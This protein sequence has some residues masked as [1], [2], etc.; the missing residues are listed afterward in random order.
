MKL[1]VT[2]VLALS[3][4]V[5]GS[6]TE[7]WNVVVPETDERNVDEVLVCNAVPP[8][9]A[10]YH[11][12]T[13]AA[14]KPLGSETDAVGI[15][16]PHCDESVPTGAVGNGLTVTDTFCVTEQPLLVAVAVKVVGVD[17]FA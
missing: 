16:A 11:L 13:R 17:G 10:A 5:V 1:T 3:H 14:G 15:P 7:T 4:P 6:V 9:E 12:N 8:V 2:G